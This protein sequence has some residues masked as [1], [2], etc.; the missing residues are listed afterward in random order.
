ML[1]SAS[2]LGVLIYVAKTGALMALRS[3]TVQN[4][5]LSKFK[6]K[7]KPMKPVPEYLAIIQAECKAHNI[8]PDLMSAIISLESGWRPKETKYEINYKYLWHPEHYAEA[9]NNTVEV[10]TVLQKTSFGLCQLM[11]ANARW[12]SYEA[13]LMT[14]FDPAINIRLG[15]KYFAQRCS[16]YS[17]IQDKIA[18]Y[19]AGT[20]RKKDGVYVNQLY[21]D[22][23]LGY[24]SDL[25]KSK[26]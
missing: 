20:P 5:I 23:V 16:Q 21:V 17:S 3:P 1:I 25:K 11:G 2:L 9:E 14:L 4:F 7:P 24:Y 19:N 26:T 22:L 12:L 8:D 13:P 6:R 10:E 15:V 18:A